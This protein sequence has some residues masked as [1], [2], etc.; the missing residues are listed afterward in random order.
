MEEKQ[1][2]IPIFWKI[3]GG[4]I[5]GLM[6]VMFLLIVNSLNSN[7]STI[8]TDL[9]ADIV[10]I[11]E[12]ITAIK[13]QMQVKADAD[14]KFTKIKEDLAAVRTQIAA[15]EESRNAT[16]DKMLALESGIRDANKI[17]ET[18]IQ[19]MLVHSKEVDAQSEL[20]RE[21]LFTQLREL[22]EKILILESKFGESK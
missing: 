13:T 7:T 15:I 18:A 5:I 4:A 22:R 11:K 1:D 6:G 14:D 20:L 19:N 17:N 21:K 10:R 2:V 12:E 9:T 16:K 3:F 8:R